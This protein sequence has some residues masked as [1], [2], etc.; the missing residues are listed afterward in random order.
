MEINTFFDSFAWISGGRL[1]LERCWLTCVGFS[2]TSRLANITYDLL[3]N[4]KVDI[5]YENSK[6]IVYKVELKYDIINCKLWNWMISRSLLW[7]LAIKIYG[8][9]WLIEI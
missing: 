2:D 9:Y 1:G 7:N 4:D 8:N 5:N 6:R 3:F